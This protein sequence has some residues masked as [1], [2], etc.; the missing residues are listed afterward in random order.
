MGEAAEGWETAERGNGK[1]ISADGAYGRFDCFQQRRRWLGFL[2]AV[3]QKY[4]DDQGSYLVATVAYY[5][6]FSV[7]PLLL[8]FTTALGFML[9]GHAHLQ[10]QIVNSAL[11]QFPVIGHELKAHS[12]TGSTLALALGAGGALWAGMGAVLAAENAMNQLWGVPFKRRPDFVRARL[13]ALLLLVVFGGGV[14]AATLLAGAG[15]GPMC[16]PP[17]PADAY[18]HGRALA[19]DA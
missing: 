15:T 9:R 14:L 16:T 17:N 10:G 18:W 11:G 1:V 19:N 8:V 13:R 12:L 3:R 5:G 2:L 7:F 6:F 4:A